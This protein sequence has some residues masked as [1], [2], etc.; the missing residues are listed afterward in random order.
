M[1]LGICAITL[2][3]LMQLNADGQAQSEGAVGLERL[4]Q[5]LRDDVHACRSAQL[6]ADDKAPAKPPRLRLTIEPDHSVSYEIGDGNVVRDESRAGKT[7]RHESYSLPRGRV[8][9]SRRASQ[10]A[11]HRLVALVVTHVAGKS[12]TDPPRPLEGRGG[13]TGKDRRSDQER[14]GGKS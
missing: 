11:A 4:S 2:Q 8:A 10:E 7:V 9:R 12:R 13:C 14:E 5:Q 3:L 1:M 6:A